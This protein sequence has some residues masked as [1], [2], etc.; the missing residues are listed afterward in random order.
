M[1]RLPVR[2]LTPEEEELERKRADLARLEAE[3][4]ER[5]LELATLQ[6]E[7]GAF[8]RRYLEIVGR[9]YAELDRLEAEIA[10]AV[11][12]QHPGNKSAETRAESAR[13]KARES[14]D[15]TGKVGPSPPGRDFKPSESLRRLY[16]Q[17]VMALH[18]D[19]TTDPAEKERRHRFMAEINKAY[20]DGDE[21]RI[22][23]I[24]R[25]WQAS[26]ESV[27]ADGPGAELVRVIRKTAQVRNRLEAIERELAQVRESEL[28]QL[29]A[30]VEEG[31]RDGRDLL[32]EMAHNVDEQIAIAREQ[33]A[34]MGA[35]K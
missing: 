24:L 10:E 15:A 2:S 32:A 5:E 28:F 16:R 14:A 30:Q 27:V 6:A 3:L 20:A 12:R 17:A 33:I 35:R 13:A 7:L 8:E 1:S 25:E 18:P 19:L 26:P 21:E 11:A 31:D 23:Q 9:Q 22:R 4:S 34:S 29:K